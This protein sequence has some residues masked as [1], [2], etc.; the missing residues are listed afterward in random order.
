[1]MVRSSLKLYNALRSSLVRLLNLLEKISM[2]NNLSSR[3]LRNV[4]ITGSLFLGLNVDLDLN[5]GYGNGLSSFLK[6]HVS[7]SFLPY[8]C[9]SVF[10]FS[11]SIF[12]AVGT[13]F[14]LLDK[15]KILA[16]E[17]FLLKD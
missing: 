11:L 13:N 15:R 3:H 12:L 5:F 17:R 14:R 9:N 2:S 16:S 6:C 8:S 7:R 10:N 1:M 4:S